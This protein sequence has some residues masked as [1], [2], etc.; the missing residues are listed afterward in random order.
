MIWLFFFFLFFFF[1]LKDFIFFNSIFNVDLCES[2][3]LRIVIFSLCIIFFFSFNYIRFKEW[4][5][6][7]SIFIIVSIFV[8]INFFCNSHFFFLLSLEMCVYPIVALILNF[9]KDFDKLSS[10]LFI[11]RLNILGSLP[12]MIFS[13]KSYSI[14]HSEYL[15]ILRQTFFLL[16]DNFLLLC[17]VLILIS[18]LPLIFFHFWLTKAHVRASGPCSIVLASLILKLGSFGLYKFCFMFFFSSYLVLEFCVSFSLYGSIFFCALITRFIDLKHLVACSS[19]L[20]MRII[21]PF[22]L[23]GTSEGVVGSLYI[24]TGHGLVSYFLFFALT[25][26]Y[27][28]SFRRSSDFNKSLESFSKTF[29]FV[30]FGLLFLNIGFPPFIN[31]F[32]ELIFC[33]FLLKFSLWSLLFFRLVILVCVVFTMFFVTKSLFGKKNLFYSSGSENSLFFLFSTTTIRLLSLPFLIYSCS[34]I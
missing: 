17:F 22:L 31:F 20:H 19:I 7:C 6:Y 18:K 11:F 14:F 13:F 1:S 33:L 25:I 27:E 9:S 5:F 3:I 29:S 34:L 8:R 4:W 10:V 2:F 23:S 16:K 30:I 15:N 28:F 26:L 21:F 24:M 12:F 32:S